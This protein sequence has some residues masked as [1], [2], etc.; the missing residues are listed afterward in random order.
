MIS[1]KEPQANNKLY[2]THLEL[3]AKC[4]ILNIKT[5]KAIIFKI[6]IIIIIIIIKNKNHSGQLT[7]TTTMKI[8]GNI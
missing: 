5:Q 8:C 2:I 7:T 1:K 4:I 3:K 6:K